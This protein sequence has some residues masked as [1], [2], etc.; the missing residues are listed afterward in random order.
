MCDYLGSFLDRT[1][2]TV[3]GFTAVLL[4]VMP[5]PPPPPLVYRQTKGRE[6]RA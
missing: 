2:W 4:A 6:L 1:G 5:P 3:V